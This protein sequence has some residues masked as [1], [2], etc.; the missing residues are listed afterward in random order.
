MRM[1]ARVY[2]CKFDASHNGK[3]YVKIIEG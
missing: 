1:F 3:F 2:F